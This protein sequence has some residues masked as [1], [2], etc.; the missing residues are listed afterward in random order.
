LQCCTHPQSGCGHRQG[1]PRDNFGCA[2]VQLLFLTLHV[3]CLL[4]NIPWPLTDSCSSHAQI[5]DSGAT[6]LAHALGKSTTLHALILG[7]QGI[8]PE[9]AKALGAVLR[10]NLTLEELYVALGV[11]GTCIDERRLEC[12]ETFGGFWHVVPSPISVHVSKHATHSKILFFQHHAV[13]DWRIK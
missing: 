13:A 7:G 2:Q 1:G 6:E 10:S 8:G 9:G 12:D 3:K 11:R 5:G 4:P